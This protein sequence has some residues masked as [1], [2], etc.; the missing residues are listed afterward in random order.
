M[1]GKAA[2]LDINSFLGTET[3]AATPAAGLNVD[4]FLGS[5]EGSPAGPT[6]PAAPSGAGHLVRLG[7]Q[8]LEQGALG[9]SMV[10]DALNSLFET[11][12]RPL[13][14]AGL[15]VSDSPESREF[16]AKANASSNPLVPLDSQALM[17]SIS[18]EQPNGP[19]ERYGAAGLRGLGG[20]VVS[21]PFGGA[22]APALALGSGTLGGTFAEGAKDLGAP[23][24]GQALAGM[25]PGLALGGWA[26]ARAAG[27]EADRAKE[28]VD[29]A[30]KALQASKNNL[31]A[32]G[33]SDPA[34]SVV[35]TRQA[36]AQSSLLAQHVLGD[37]TEKSGQARDA[38]IASVNG[39]LALRHQAVA[40]SREAVASSLGESSTLQEAG[41]ALQSHAREWLTHTVPDLHSDLWSLVDAGISDKQP[42][43]LEGFEHALNSMST[44]SGEL[45]PLADVLGS[46]APKALA[47][48]YN[49]LTDDPTWKDVKNF[50]SVLGEAMADPSTVNK[51]P[52]QNLAALYAG[53]T[54]DMKVTAS[55]AGL[56]KE[57][58]DAA[59]GSK[60]LFDLAEGPVAKVVASKS[61]SLANDPKPED[62]AS[63]LLT[64]G[65][66]GDSDLAALTSAGFPTGELAAAGLRSEATPGK[67][68]NGL[69][70]EAK[71]TLVPDSPSRQAIES[72]IAEHS[73]AL[74]QAKAKTALASAKHD[75]DVADA[76]S[77]LTF[78]P[79]TLGSS[80]DAQL[81]G[82]KQE[83]LR[84]QKAF[85]AASAS[86]PAPAS[87]QHLI[88]LLQTIKTHH[89]GAAA[90]AIIEHLASS[91][92]PAE[93]SQIGHAALGG[94]A[95]HYVAGMLN[96]LY[97]GVKTAVR[98]PGGMVGPAA[99]L[100]GASA[101]ALGS[102]APSSAS[103]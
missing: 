46:G 43:R 93:I 55:H 102:S 89:L 14:P 96:P 69:S 16:A 33:A 11:H 61:P 37:F 72:G 90:G 13:L 100:A 41:S 48:A 40:D 17:K 95:G 10:P 88:D 6:A 34:S 79:A 54:S 24:W 98:R 60:Q 51:I 15:Q 56:L 67:L 42:M 9:A 68:W 20:A 63:R 94:L 81:A 58:N 35:Q 30:S 25:I 57:F 45:Q 7:G 66:K 36:A 18:T 86:V 71:A 50:R 53:L 5:E 59:A 84:A 29:V 91:G 75:L 74:A 103:P 12:V 49:G 26:G 8:A 64:G 52:R 27:A 44:K 22:A 85:D 70:P 76:K 101:N 82:L 1:A 47:K 19:L 73:D 28:A 38:T 21:L 3:P 62:V 99:G 83:K 39:E 32:V 77:R 31:E 65:K 4:Q 78:G 97:Q 87:D 2:P 23:G 92:A 80:A